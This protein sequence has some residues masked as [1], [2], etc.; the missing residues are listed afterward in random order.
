MHDG[1]ELQCWEDG[2][3]C[4]SRVRF[5]GCVVE[6]SECGGG[7][8]GMTVALREGVPIEAGC[9]TSATSDLDFHTS[10]LRPQ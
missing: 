1:R 10:S 2:V 9:P 5:W 3:E 6:Y 7:A 8:S 4:G